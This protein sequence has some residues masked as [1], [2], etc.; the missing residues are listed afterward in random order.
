[1][2]IIYPLSNESV[3]VRGIEHSFGIVGAL[4][5]FFDTD[6]LL[7]SHLFKGWQ[8]YFELAAVG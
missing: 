4:A 8:P 5:T 3:G 7:S 2:C 1:M 6:F